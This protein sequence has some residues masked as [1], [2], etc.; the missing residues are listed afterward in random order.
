MPRSFNVILTALAPA[1]WG[2][3]YIVTTELLPDGYPIT[4]AMLRALP[5]GL[6][7]LLFVH[8]LP[9]GRW[10]LRTFVLG[11]LNFSVFWW[12]L[13]VAAYRLP[14]GV[15]A[16]IGAVQPL[17]VLFLARQ[18]LNQAIS[19]A[20]LVAGVVGVFGVALLVL[21]PAATLDGIGMLAAFGGAASMALGTILTKTWQPP[22]SPLTFTAWQ[23]SAGGLLLLPM[24]LLFEPPLPPLSPS[25]IAGFVYL[26]LIGGASTYILWFRGIALLGPSAVAPLGRLSP[27]AAVLLGWIILNQTL[28]ALQLVGMVLALASAWFGQRS[29]QTPPTVPR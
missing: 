16:T 12:L 17:I 22:V 28:N 24:A 2:S 14:G 9:R 21:T 18:M 1:I 20:A 11:A 8:S 3:T 23:L 19:T 27:V 26:G 25:N 15:A 5:S 4:A 13:F 6:L 7:L 10:I 29:Q